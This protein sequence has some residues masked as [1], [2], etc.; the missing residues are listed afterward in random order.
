MTLVEGCNA[1]LQHYVFVWSTLFISGGDLFKNVKLTRADCATVRG[2][3]VGQNS[4]FDRLYTL[5]YLRI[6]T[7]L[8]GNTSNLTFVFYFYIQRAL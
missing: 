3:T 8:E 4:T 5:E 6:R 2:E 1:E 7:A